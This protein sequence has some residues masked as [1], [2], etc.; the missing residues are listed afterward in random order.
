M[1]NNI[2][3]SKDAI[4]VAAIPDP[5]APP[6]KKRAVPEEPTFDKSN[7]AEQLWLA[8]KLIQKQQK[9]LQAKY[10]D[11]ELPVINLNHNSSNNKPSQQPHIYKVNCPFLPPK[12]KASGKRKVQKMMKKK[13]NKGICNILRLAFL[14]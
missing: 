11:K 12:A 1:Y 10:P 13:K 6:A 8:I 7:D 14:F 9:M 2:N 3:P 5:E 4:A